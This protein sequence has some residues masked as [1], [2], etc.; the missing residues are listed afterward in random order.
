MGKLGAYPRVV[1]ILDEGYTLPFKMRPPLT[2]SPVIQSGYAMQTRSK[3]ISQRGI[4]GSDKEVASGKSGCPLIPSLSQP[5]IS[6]PE[7][8]Q[9]METYFRPQS[10]KSVS[11]SRYRKYLRFS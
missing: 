4:V 3:P 10:V 8:Q 2:R 11:Q 6:S 5:V 1:S 9:Q 7:T